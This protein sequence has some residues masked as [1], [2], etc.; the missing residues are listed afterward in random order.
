MFLTISTKV[1]YLQC[2]L[3]VTWLVSCETAATSTHS[4]YITHSLIICMDPELGFATHAAMEMSLLTDN[5]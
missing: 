2:Y 1:V 4:V 5:L 3:V